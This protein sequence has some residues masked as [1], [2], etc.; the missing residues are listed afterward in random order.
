MVVSKSVL[1]TQCSKKFAQLFSYLVSLTFS[2]LG[3]HISYFS[4]KK[5][6]RR[7]KWHFF[8][9]QSPVH[10]CAWKKPF[11]D[12]EAMK[13]IWCS[14]TAFFGAARQNFNGHFIFILFLFFWK[15]CSHIYGSYF[16]FFQARASSGY[17]NSGGEG[18]AFLGKS[19]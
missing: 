19:T 15:K 9:F 16:P 17:D 10:W 8:I 6:Q 14:L 5:T 7:D 11:P 12:R 2:L 18:R 13:A 1:K 3:M 4:N